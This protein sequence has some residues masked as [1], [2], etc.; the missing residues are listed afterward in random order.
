MDFRASYGE[1]I[2]PE[3]WLMR[4][5]W[6]KVNVTQGSRAGLAK[7]PIKF[8]SSG[9]RILMGRAWNIQNVRGIL[10][11]GEKRHEFKSTHGFRKFFKSN[12][13]QT[14]K[15]LHVEM[16]MG[17]NTG[18]ARNYYRPNENEI[19]N[20]YYKAIPYL[21]INDEYRLSKQVQELKQQDDYQKYVIDKKMKEKDEEIANMRQ[22]MRTVSESVNKMKN[23]FIVLQREKLERNKEIKDD[24]SKIRDD[25][26][27]IK[28]NLSTREILT[29]ILE[30]VD[31][32]REEVF[33]KK[34]LVT[35]ED[36]EAIKNSILEDIKQ[37]DPNLAE[38]ILTR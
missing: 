13:E 5:T 27:R 34:G 2:T 38:F 25:F 12:C 36:E 11:E 21:T 32:K 35:K 1:N 24:F 37:N 29:Q 16:I 33:A 17:H 6:K 3:S 22:A 23:D 14:M 30:K 9:I 15:S 7:K 8:K 20:E 26:R 4:N 28:S 10:E 31:Q 18:L 19:L